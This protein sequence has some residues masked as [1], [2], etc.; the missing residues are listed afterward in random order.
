MM[1][2]Q[3][4]EKPMWD[5]R[6]AWLQAK[7]PQLTTSEDVAAN[8]LLDRVKEVAKKN[9]VQISS[10]VLRPAAH[11]PDYSAISVD[12]ETTSTWPSL[13]G[14]MKELQGPEQFIVLEGVNLKI[15]EQGRDANARHVQDRAMVLAEAEIQMNARRTTRCL[16]DRSDAGTIFGLP[17]K[18]MKS[19]L[20]LIALTTAAAQAA[21]VESAI[22]TLFPTERYETMIVKSPFALATPPAPVAAPAEKNFA[23]G[24]Y[25][26]SLAQLEG[27]D[28]VTIKSRDQGVQLSLFG[29]EPKDGVALQKVEWSPSIGRSTVTI[30]K[31]GQSAKL[32]FNQA[33]LQ[34]AAPPQPTPGRPPMPI[35]TNNA[36][37]RPVIP[38]PTQPVV[39]GLPNQ[40]FQNAG[41]GFQNAGRTNPVV[42]PQPLQYGGNANVGI[43]KPGA[44]GV[45]PASDP[46]RRIRVINNAP[47]Q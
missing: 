38:R 37:P 20:F 33:E 4:A 6:E 16:V 28:F 42:Q 47:T 9:A 35:T 11:Q 5:Q 31:D 43:P 34:S 32:E 21:T 46:R 1:R 14:F 2:R 3:M 39:Q 8:Q 7:Q 24:W 12:L 15:D 41:Q 22:P 13:I 40:G 27:K 17:R 10:P 19:T 36:A 26:T 25:V 18:Y 44:P 29:D 45:A 30:V 23:D